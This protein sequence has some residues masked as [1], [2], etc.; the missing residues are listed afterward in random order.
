MNRWRNCGSVRP[1]WWYETN[2]EKRWPTTDAEMNRLKE[3]RHLVRQRRLEL[4]HGPTDGERAEI[5]NV[6]D[7]L[8]GGLR[9]QALEEMTAEERAELAASPPRRSG[10]TWM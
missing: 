5:A 1:S 6:L 3:E 10:R 7:P 8:V 9:N 4:G 2:L